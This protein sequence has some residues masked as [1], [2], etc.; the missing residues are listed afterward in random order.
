MSNCD[1]FRAVKLRPHT[2]CDA[3]TGEVIDLATELKVL[4]SDVHLVTDLAEWHL[5]EKLRDDVAAFDEENNSTQAMAVG[6]YLG[7]TVPPEIL[8]DRKSG[9]SRLIQLIQDRTVREARSWVKRSDVARGTN[10]FYANAGFKRTARGTRPTNLKPK[11]SLSAANTQYSEILAAESGELTL[12]MVIGGQWRILVFSFD[13]ER[14]T[15]WYKI[16][17]PD[18]I[19]VNGKPVF[20]FAFAYKYTYT[21]FSER[22]IVGVD[23]GIAEY[24]AVSVVDV[25]TGEIVEST[26]LSARVHSLYNKTRAATKQVA[27]LH[28]KGRSPEAVPHREANSRRKKELAI[29]AGKEVAEIAYR[30]GNAL[31][32]FEDLSWITNTMSHGRWNRGEFYSQTTRAVEFNGGRVFTVNPA[33]TSQQCHLCGKPV[34]FRERI[35]VCQ[36]GLILDRDINAAANIALRFVRSGTATKVITT[37]QKAKRVTTKQLKRT[38]GGSGAPLRYP[39]RKTQPTPKRPKVVTRKRTNNEGSPAAPTTEK[40]GESQQT[41]RGSCCE[42]HKAAHQCPLTDTQGYTLDKQRLRM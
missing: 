40:Y 15:G 5:D 4:A 27:A 33:Y 35:A 30:Y 21:V 42:T 9:N 31:V 7:I 14:Y 18:I 26:T 16:C 39:R 32:V 8:A 36:C 37:R 20:S 22:Y 11:M 28:R 12:K 6:H 17:R 19:L 13:S 24:A 25:T 23:V 29:L 41:K 34:S 38:K 1:L 2:V 3:K 10:N